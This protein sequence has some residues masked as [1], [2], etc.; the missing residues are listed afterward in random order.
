[1]EKITK[2]SLFFEVWGFGTYR[3]EWYGELYKV[4]N[5]KS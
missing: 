4:Y 3:D 2:R 1:V 5:K